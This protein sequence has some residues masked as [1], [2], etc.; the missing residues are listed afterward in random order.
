MN[1]SLWPPD[2]GAKL[3]APGTELKAGSELLGS[4]FQRMSTKQIVKKT[5]VNPEVMRIIPSVS[6]WEHRLVSCPFRVCRES[7]EHVPVNNHTSHCQ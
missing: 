3:E 4:K 1:F 7:T 6:G 5:P 2:T